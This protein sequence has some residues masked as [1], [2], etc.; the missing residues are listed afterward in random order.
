MRGFLTFPCVLAIATFALA[1]GWVLKAP[2]EP[3]TKLAWN[4]HVDAN[5]GGQNHEAIMKQTVSFESKSEKEIKGSASWSEL[6]VDGQD[7]GGE[8]TAWSLTLNPNGTI[9]SAGE[10]DDY[11]RMLA[12]F[13]FAYPDKEVKVGDKWTVKFVPFKDAREMTAAYEVLE[14]TKVGEIEALKV[15]G[16]L[17]DAGSGLVSD[18]SYWVGKDGKVLK[19]DLDVKSWVVPMAGAGEFDAKIKGELAKK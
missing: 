8:D 15:K 19:F 5:M 13:A 2:Y 14:Q 17:T 7:M 9:A 12:P 18:G 16:K 4:I 1:Q 10:S 6:Q 11:S 3:K